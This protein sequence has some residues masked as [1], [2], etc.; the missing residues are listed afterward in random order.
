MISLDASSRQ[1]GKQYN[2]ILA[3]LQ[4]HKHVHVSL[5]YTADTITADRRFPDIGTD[6]T[7]ALLPRHGCI[8]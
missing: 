7:K 1:G 3:E 4:S 5:L 6:W 2:R 8:T